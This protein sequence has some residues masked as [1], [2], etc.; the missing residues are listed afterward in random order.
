MGRRVS[1]RGRKA[2]VRS[3]SAGGKPWEG[4]SWHGILPGLWVRGRFRHASAWGDGLRRRGA[5]GQIV[6]K[7]PLD[8]VKLRIL[9]FD[10]VLTNDSLVF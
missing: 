7:F 4:R 2:P 9:S 10:W 6:Q 8:P 5:A 1:S 3:V